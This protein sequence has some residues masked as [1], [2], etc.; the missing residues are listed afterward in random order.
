QRVG[1]AEVRKVLEDLAKTAPEHDEDRSFYSDWRDPREY[2]TGDIGIG[3]CAGEVVT[4]Y[5]FAMTDAERLVF[6]GEMELEKG[7]IQ[8]AGKNA[9][10]GMLRSAKALVQT[11]Y[12]DVSNDPKEIV[13]EF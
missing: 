10:A 9:Y 1:K 13:D 5:Q 11:Q 3:E 12:D 4:A 2:S 6:Q 7:N 8:Q